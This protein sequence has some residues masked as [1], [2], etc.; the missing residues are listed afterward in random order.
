MNSGLNRSP[1]IY[2]AENSETIHSPR[3]HCK[4]SLCLS[5]NAGT[6]HA[7]K[8]RTRFSLRKTKSW[9]RR[10]DDGLGVEN[11]GR[12]VCTTVRPMTAIPFS[13]CLRRDQIRDV[14]VLRLC[15]LLDWVSDRGDQIAFPARRMWIIVGVARALSE[16][17]TARRQWL[18]YSRRWGVWRLPSY[19]VKDVLVVA[20]HTE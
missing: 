16:A 2:S 1:V 14:G 18:I 3:A 20:E 17:W 6:T 4:P 11:I 15:Q 9:K 13:T 19:T 7:G 5:G 10:R 8:S 12:F